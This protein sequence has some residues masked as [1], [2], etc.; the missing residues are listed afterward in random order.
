M[1]PW[2]FR[3]VAASGE[4]CACDVAGCW[5]LAG[6]DGLVDEMITFLRQWAAGFDMMPA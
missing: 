4:R 5:L 3:E 1:P 6:F 2:K